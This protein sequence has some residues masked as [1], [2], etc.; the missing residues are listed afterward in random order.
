[1]ARGPDPEIRDVD[2]LEV[3]VSNIDE[4][5]FVP[6]ELGDALDVTAEGARHQMD[7]LVDRGLLEK[8]KPGE[9]TVL[10]WVTHQG[11]RHYAQNSSPT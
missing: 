6:S 5:A 10:Y 2:L 7:N 8:K 4:G 11:I 1:M 9:R 3:F